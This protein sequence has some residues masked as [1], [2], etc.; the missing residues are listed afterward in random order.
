MVQAEVDTSSSR[1]GAHVLC[2]RARVAPARSHAKKEPSMHL[3]DACDWTTAAGMLHAM[4]CSC[5]TASML[6]KLSP[7]AGGRLVC[8]A[9]WLCGN[10]VWQQLLPPHAAVAPP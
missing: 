5:T 7:T 10:S 8:P 6:E 3:A 4:L 1:R 2:A 9:S